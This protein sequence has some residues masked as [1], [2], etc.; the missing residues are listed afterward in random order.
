MYICF[1]N[2]RDFNDEKFRV[3][4]P[5]KRLI[6]ENKKPSK[7]AKLDEKG[8]GVLKLVLSREGETDK[9]KSKFI[10][11]PSFVNDNASTSSAE[12]TNAEDITKLTK[13][14]NSLIGKIKV[15]DPR[16]MID[17]VNMGRF[18]SLFLEKKL[19]KAQ[20]TGIKKFVI[21]SNYS[22]NMYIAKRGNLSLTEIEDLYKKYF[23]KS[24]QDS[25]VIIAN[26]LNVISMS[27]KHHKSRMDESFKKRS[28]AEKLKER[29]DA[30]RIH[31]RHKKVL[32]AKLKTTF[33]EVILTFSTEEFEPA[34]Q[35]FFLSILTV[36]RVLDQPKFKRGSIF[37]N[38]VLLLWNS[39]KS[40]EF[41]HARIFNMFRSKSF[42]PDCIDL[43]SLI[44]DTR[45]NDPSI[46]DRMALFFVSSVSSKDC[47]QCVIN[48]VTGDSVEDLGQ[49]IENAAQQLRSCSK[50]KEPQQYLSSTAIQPSPKEISND[51]SKVI[52]DVIH[53]TDDNS[54]QHWVIAKGPNGLYQ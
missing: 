5:K 1:I 21:P 13:S 36:L 12:K 37:K 17:E 53:P 33:N 25:I 9:F 4:N 7:K 20:R 15:R 41:E 30:N 10:S 32:E 23:S 40:S 38:L 43:I 2:F 26:I 44:E 31:T 3:P 47:F 18:N 28:E 16:T 29:C 22:P 14:K 11:S 52:S 24:I 19:P 8:P 45:D 51:Q 54:Q 49:L 50:F 27:N 39:L 6:E 34:F 42:R 46:T 48:A 35:M